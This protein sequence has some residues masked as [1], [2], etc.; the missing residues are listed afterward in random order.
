M[1]KD[2]STARPWFE[3]W[4]GKDYLEVYSHRDQ[5]EACRQIDLMERVL[6]P[7]RGARI[8]DLC[9]GGGRHSIELARRGYRVSGIDLSKDLLEQ[10]TADTEE[11]GLDAEF[12]RADMRSVIAPNAFDVVVNFF[13]S[14]GYFDS[15]EENLRVLIAIRESLRADGA[16][17]MDYLNRDR[18][19][20]TLVP[21]D[22][23]RI[24]NVE[25]RQERHVDPVRGRVN[26]TLTITRDDAAKVY[27]ESVRMYTFAELVTMTQAAGL[28]ITHVFGS[29]DG[30]PF[31][32]ESPR[33]LLAGGVS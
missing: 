5:A 28:R 7:P 17:M 2:R 11:A 21:F 10:A 6:N 8:E 29:D 9:C 20:S 30:S 26:K 25:L 23:Q 15:D 19:I 18:V 12:V 4:F 1:E 24:G 13:T 27:H 3:E 22:S 16:W 31:T 33:L 32:P 14:F